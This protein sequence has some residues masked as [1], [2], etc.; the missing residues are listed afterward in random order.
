M[1][2]P[3]WHGKYILSSVIRTLFFDELQQPG[4]L[5]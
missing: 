3:G 5:T 2:I 4:L 1:H